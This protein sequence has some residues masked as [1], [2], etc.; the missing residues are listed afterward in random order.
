MKKAIMIINANIEVVQQIKHNLTSPDA[1]IVCVFSMREALQTFT[2]KE[3][4]LIILD[5]AISAEDDHQL[6]SAIRKSK[7]TGSYG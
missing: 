5:A 7:T 4:C 2:K 1:E 6:L 3:F